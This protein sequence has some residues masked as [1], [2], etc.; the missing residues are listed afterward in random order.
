MVHAELLAVLGPVGVA[1]LGLAA[2]TTE[3]ACTDDATEDVTEVST[4]DVTAKDVTDDTAE[5]V[6]TED[7]EDA[8]RSPLLPPATA[9]KRRRDECPCTDLV[10]F[11]NARPAFA[12]APLDVPLEH[13]SIRS[14]TCLFN[15]VQ[16]SR[17]RVVHDEL[18]SLLGERAF[19]KLKRQSS[20]PEPSTVD[21]AAANA[22]EANCETRTRTR[23]DCSCI[24]YVDRPN[25]RAAFAATPRGTPRLHSSKCFRECLCNVRDGAQ[26]ERYPLIYNELAGMLG[27]RSFRALVNARNL[28]TPLG[29]SIPQSDD[30]VH[31]SQQCPTCGNARGSTDLE[32]LTTAPRRRS[33][34]DAFIGLP[35]QQQP[36]AS[37]QDD[38]DDAFVT[39][40]RTAMRGPL[41]GDDYGDDDGDD[42]DELQQEVLQP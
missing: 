38:D 14:S 6:T 21:A 7:A 2:L 39:R 19:K 18:M 33:E 24:D 42:D 25:A 13:H 1:L 36:P 35:P 27:G 8:D 5:D 11:L 9:T 34:L 12:A 17:Y 40:F 28:Q 30:E 41:D 4:S 15:A 16:K 37:P 20:L 22:S 32:D 3:D 26:N 23:R 29:L 10:A 31:T